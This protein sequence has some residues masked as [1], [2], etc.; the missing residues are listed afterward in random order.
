MIQTTLKNLINVLDADSSAHPVNDAQVHGIT[1]DSRAI[2]PSQAFVAIRGQRFDGH[3]FAAAAARQGAACII[4][5]YAPAMPSDKTTPVLIVN[6]TVGALATLARWYRRQLSA[7]VIA[8]TGSAGKTTVRHMLHH[9]LSRFYK[10]HQA[11]G[12]FNNHIGVPLTILSAPADCQVLLTELGTNHPGE[13]EPLAR[14]ANP[15]IA[16]ITLIGPAHLECLGSLKNILIEKASIAKG[17]KPGGT[18]IIN[19]DQPDLVAYAKTLDCRIKTFG[20]TD[21]CDIIGND[22]ISDGLTGTLTIEGRAITLPLPGKANLINALT[23]WSICRDLKVALSDF[24][25]AM[26]D[27]KPFPMRLATETIGSLTLL[28]DCYN[29]SPVSTA[30][31]LDTLAHMAKQ[32]RQRAVFVAG[33]MG[34]LGPGAARLHRR[35]GQQ[36]ADAGVVCLLACG[37]FASD[38]VQ[39]ARQAGFDGTSEIFKTTAELCDK[40]HSFVRPADIILV[41][42]SR[43]AALEAA[44]ETIKHLPA[45]SP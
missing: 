20:T 22:L 12:S 27:L 35:L 44:V 29:A 18:L 5:E 19:G 34:E 16:C 24:A 21:N 40:L 42:G 37:P 31:A 1:I 30:N 14:I 13:I 33:S 7:T 45:V 25:E 3:D 38:I 23:V 11:A 4:A 15:D 8:I 39:G 26:A 36:A 32:T 28:N 9:V 43:S 6:D 17:L 2:L 41:K 10:S